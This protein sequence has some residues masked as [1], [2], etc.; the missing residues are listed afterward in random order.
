MGCTEP[1]PSILQKFG[2]GRQMPKRPGFASH[3]NSTLPTSMYKHFD[4]PTVG[5]NIY[6]SV[7]AINQP[8]TRWNW[9]ETG[10]HVDQVYSYLDSNCEEQGMGL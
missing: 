8:L 1:C 9:R 6:K 7:T 5:E 3:K 10:R 4:F 2:S